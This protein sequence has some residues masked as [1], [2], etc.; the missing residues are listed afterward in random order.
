MES[1]KSKIITIPNILSLLRLLLIPLMMWL[2]CVK[3]DYVMTAL[4]LIIS[5]ATDIIDG[6]IARRFNMISDFGKALD[7]IAD[8]LTQ[9]GMIVAI[10]THYPKMLLPVVL[11]IIKE[12]SAGITNLVIIKRKHQ[13]NG[14]MWHGKLTTVILYAMIF[15]H[16]VWADIPNAVSTSLIVLSVLMMLISC[17]MYM[18]KNIKILKAK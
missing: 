4:V 11:L 6:F 5:G 8:K 12:V 10:S 9:I 17:V 7:P 15:L 14:A 3:K 1:Y 13:V 2:Y 18:K 16:I